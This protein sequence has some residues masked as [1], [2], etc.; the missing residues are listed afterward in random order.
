MNTH[1]MQK[2]SITLRKARNSSSY[3]TSGFRYQKR[4]SN[5][6]YRWILYI[7]F[8]TNCYDLECFLNPKNDSIITYFNSST[9]V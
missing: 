2:D 5:F 9:S 8:T 4:I 1:F 7:Q 6:N 3:L